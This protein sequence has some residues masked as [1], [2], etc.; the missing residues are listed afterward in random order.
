VWLDDPDEAGVC[1]IPSDDR[2][3]I[4]PGSQYGH[5]STH[6]RMMHRQ[7]INANR[8]IDLCCSAGIEWMFH[9]DSD[10]LIMN[11]TGIS[12]D[13]MLA[14]GVGQLRCVNHEIWPV[15]NADNPFRECHLFKLNGRMVFNSYING[16]SAVRV[17]RSVTATGAHRF[18]GFEG[19]SCAA[20]DIV[21]LHYG[22]A[23]YEIWRKKYER[24][25]WFPDCWWDDPRHP[26][27][28]PFHLKSR[29]LLS[30][31]SKS[32]DFTAA[33]RFWRAQV[34]PQFLRDQYVLQGRAARFFPI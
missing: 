5:G 1:I 17:S 7:Q 9:I 26:I 28:L 20:N 4:N 13:Q 11:C 8:T 21:I 24:L 22:C 27:L 29:D 12:R 23:T 18:Q 19:K 25:G 33:E 30:N 2:I 34:A 16:K 32:G 31:C 15:W 3:S 14:T 10:E 6:A